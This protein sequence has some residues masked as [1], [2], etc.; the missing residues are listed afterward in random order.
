MLIAWFGGRPLD[1]PL[2]V[3]LLKKKVN[4]ILIILV[5]LLPGLWVCLEPLQTSLST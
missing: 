3:W 2:Y 5:S 4:P 1:L